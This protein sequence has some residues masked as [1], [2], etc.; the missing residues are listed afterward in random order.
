[1]SD[2]V[3]VFGVGMT[4]FGKFLEK[5]IKQLTGEVL[6]SVLKDCEDYINSDE[7]EAAWFSNSGWGISDFQHCIRGQ[8][9]LTANSIDKIPIINVENACAGASTALHGAW[10]AIKAGLYDCAL[11][12]GV[13]K[14]YSE[15][16]EKMM[17]GFI[18]ATDVERTT[19]LIE[20]LRKMA[21]KKKERE[22]KKKGDT[23]LS[24]I[25]TQQQLDSIC[26]NM[27]LHN[28]N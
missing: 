27:E 10:T 19:K 1:M 3:Y 4:K 7:I 14:G 11:A 25:F 23:L 5:S 6:E 15:D 24:W 9:A 16:R 20:Q 26:K 12:I 21:R 2:K 18:A 28:D 17:Q 22:A 13:E 8:V